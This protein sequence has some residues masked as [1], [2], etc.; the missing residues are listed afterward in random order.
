MVLRDLKLHLERAQQC[1]IREANKH[2]GDVDFAVGERVYLKFRPY[3]Q[4]SLFGAGL[5]KLARYYFGLFVVEARIGKSAYRLSLSVG[6][7]IHPIFHVSLVVKPPFL[8]DL[9]VANR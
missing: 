6:S 2:H 8:L 5:G 4:C 9:V 3:Q 7:R 1:T